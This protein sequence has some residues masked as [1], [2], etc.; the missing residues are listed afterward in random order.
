[1]AM[2][3]MAFKHVVRCWEC[4]ETLDRNFPCVARSAEKASYIIVAP[5]SMI[6]PLNAGKKEA[7][8]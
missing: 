8:H 5:T 1:M 4:F 3:M 7:S 2:P 6:N